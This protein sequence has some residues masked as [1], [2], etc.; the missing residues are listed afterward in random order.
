MQVLLTGAAILSVEKQ[1]QF[2]GGL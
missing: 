2:V 1:G